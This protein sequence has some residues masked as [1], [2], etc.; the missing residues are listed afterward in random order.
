MS[1]GL[2]IGW[3]FAQQFKNGSGFAEP[4]AVLGD[5]Q[6]MARPQ[7]RC[8]NKDGH[9]RQ[10]RHKFNVPEEGEKDREWCGWCLKRKRK[11]N[12][13]EA[14]K[15]TK[16]R[17]EDARPGDKAARTQESKDTP[18]R[19][20]AAV[21]TQRHYRQNGRGK[22]VDA[23]SKQK[24]AEK[25]KESNAAW[26][27][28]M[29]AAF[30]KMLSKFGINGLDGSFSKKAVMLGFRDADDLKEHFFKLFAPGMSFD[31]KGVQRVGGPLMWHIGHMIVP[32]CAY[33][34]ESEADQLRCF[35]KSNLAPQWA[36]ENLR[37]AR[38]MAS[39]EVLLK[40]RHLWPLAWND[41]LPSEVERARIENRRIDERFLHVHEDDVEKVL[42]EEEAKYESEDAAASGS[43]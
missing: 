19:R 5:M 29:Q 38:K 21:V 33:D 36:S 39:N 7:Q 42:A 20:A 10:C 4:G 14:G 17:Y 28:T 2:S 15:E 16:Q 6:R 1:E 35:H 9:D 27:G 13:S 11:E 26:N 37:Q 31:N 3:M 12:K 8:T 40:H 22:E 25:I 24:N 18:E 23:A 41:A 43:E 32:Q 34:R 30:C